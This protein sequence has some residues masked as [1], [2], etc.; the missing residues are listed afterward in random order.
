MSFLRY[1]QLR[2]IPTARLLE[3][4]EE[5]LRDWKDF[6]FRARLLKIRIEALENAMRNCDPFGE[7][8]EKLA[9]RWKELDGQTCN[10][11]EVF[12]EVQSY[13]SNYHE[14]E[15]ELSRRRDERVWPYIG[16]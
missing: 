9:I 14:I 6:D 4:Q 3:M 13:R 16:R 11:D 12:L 7:D 10:N 8:F 15:R 1:E 2:E 5:I